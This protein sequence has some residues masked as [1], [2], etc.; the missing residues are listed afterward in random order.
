MQVKWQ[1]IFEQCQ[2]SFHRPSLF[3]FKLLNLNYQIKGNDSSVY[4]NYLKKSAVNFQE[5]KSPNFI[6]LL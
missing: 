2:P 3:D 5:K 4:S 1:Y 6:R